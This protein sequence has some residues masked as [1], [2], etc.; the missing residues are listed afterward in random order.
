M[1]VGISVLFYRQSLI[2]VESLESVWW[3]PNF[4]HIIYHDSACLAYWEIQTIYR[5]GFCGFVS[6]QFLPTLFFISTVSRILTAEL[7]ALLKALEHFRSALR[8]LLSSI[9]TVFFL[10]YS[11]ILVHILLFFKSLNGCILPLSAS[12][13]CLEVLLFSITDNCYANQL[14]TFKPSVVPR[15]NPFHY[16]LC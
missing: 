3:C 6:K 11:P 2:S 5:Y 15:L 14:S 4:S 7:D 16:I 1:T 10:F 12:W 8:P 13:F 9:F